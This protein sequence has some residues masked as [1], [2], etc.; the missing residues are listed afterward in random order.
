MH[1]TCPSAVMWV[2][3]MRSTHIHRRDVAG[4]NRFTE[5]EHRRFIN[6]PFA[7]DNV[8]IDRH[9]IQHN[10]HSLNRGVFIATTQPTIAGQGGGFCDAGKL[11]D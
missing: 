6:L 4:V 1:L 7:Y 2:P 8:A 5:V 9:L 3:T 11:N 10:E